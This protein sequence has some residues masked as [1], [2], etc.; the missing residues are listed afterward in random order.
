MTERDDDMGERSPEPIEYLLSGVMD[1][2]VYREIRSYVRDHAYDDG[3]AILVQGEKS[4]RFHMLVSGEATVYVKNEIEVAVATLAKGDFMGE[5]SC[6]TEEPASATVRATGSVRTVSL[7]REGLFRL[8]DVSGQFR[9]HMLNI[10]V[11]RVR[12]SNQRIVDEHTKSFAVSR[13][14]ASE[15][16][17]RYGRYIMGGKHGRKLLER[18]EELASAQGP[19]W[20]VGENGTGRSHTAFE[21]HKIACPG[22][23]PCLTIEGEHLDWEDW[24]IKRKAAE[25]GTLIVRRADLLDGETRARLE[26]EAGP[27]VRLI[28]TAEQ[29]PPGNL[30]MTLRLV[31][32]RE[33]GEDIPLLALEFLRRE[34]VEMPEEAISRE[35]LRLLGMYP[36]LQGNAE[37][38][39]RVVSQALA[40]SGSKPISTSHL[41]FGTVRKPGERPKIGLAL[42]SGSVKGAAHVGVIKV[43]E[44]A[45]IP[46][47]CIA[48]TSVGAFIGALYAG[49]QPVSAFE[50]VLP[51][52]RWRQLLNPAIPP[53]ALADNRPMARFVERFIGAVD[54]DQLAVPFAAVASNALTGEAHILNKGRVSRAICATTAI[55][56]LMKPVEYDGQLLIDGAVVHPVP[57][58][59]C[60]SMGADIVI[61]VDVSAPASMRRKPGNIVSA[62]LNTIDI[63][64]DKIV[65]EEMQ[66]ADVVLRPQL[67]VQEYTFKSSSAF[68]QKGVE[69]T[70]QALSDILKQVQQAGG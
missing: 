31:P 21:I 1:E 61:A 42:G 41:R 62:I 48:G 25:G 29:S 50:R 67:E 65:Q 40:L 60:K 38:L 44:E 10:M 58:A 14:L 7:P 2:Q 30:A 57:V 16:E 13:Q 12:R 6:L 26:R 36:Y 68:I 46:I 33:R 4:S 28:L 43:M 20:I 55:P 3:Q 8:M 32:L 19:V 49:G 15:R 63:M 53:K 5:M 35:A 24:R 56:G 9:N 11:N 18:M 22:D 39:R 52:V 70:R 37:E 54:F 64:S 23:R 34:G 69:V 51:T 47:D 59:L 45:G 27:G 66:L 17:S